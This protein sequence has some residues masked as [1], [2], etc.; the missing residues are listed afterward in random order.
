MDTNGG[1][2]YG[3]KVNDSFYANQ[4]I[5]ITG[6]HGIILSS[7]LYNY[8][9]LDGMNTWDWSLVSAV[10]SAS[11]KNEFECMVQ[12]LPNEYGVYF[13]LISWDSEEDDS[14]SFL[15]QNKGARGP[16]YADEETWNAG[17]EDDNIWAVDIGS[18]KGVIVSPGW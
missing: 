17:V 3:F 12:N 14:T 10:N 15:V 6:Q 11:D 13:H 18:S 4:L 1:V 7:V 2:P 9:S 8:T 5:E 16:S